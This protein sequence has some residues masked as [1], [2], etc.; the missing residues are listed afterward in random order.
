M[1]WVQDMTARWVVVMS[2]TGGGRTSLD[3]AAQLINTISEI[4]AKKSGFGRLRPN[5]STPAEASMVTV[6]CRQ[7]IAAVVLSDLMIDRLCALEGQTREQVLAR[8]TGDFPD[9]LQDLQ[10]R[11]LQVELSGSCELLKDPERATYAALGGRIADLLGRAEEQASALIDA[12]RAEAAEIT[13]AARAEA[14][15]I[16]PSASAHGPEPH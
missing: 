1:D 5:A 4:P 10:L 9:Q 11:A 12:A 6:L 8:L 14:A 3:E 13:S 16:N 2:A 7:L 15:E